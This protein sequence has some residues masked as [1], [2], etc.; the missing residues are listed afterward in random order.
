M[1]LAKLLG[2]PHAGPEHRATGQDHAISLP[3]D[4]LGL[5]QLDGLGFALEDI[6]VGPGVT[7]RNG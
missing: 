5:A 4:D 7:D 2:G 6:K 1:E 3:V